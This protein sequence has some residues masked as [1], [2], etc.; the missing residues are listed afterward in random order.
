MKRLLPL[1]L[2]VTSLALPAAAFATLQVTKTHIGA[3]YAANVG[4]GRLFGEQAEAAGDGHAELH[5]RQRQRR[6]QVR[7]RDAEQ[8]RAELQ[9]VRERQWRSLGDGVALGKDGARV[10]VHSSGRGLVVVSL[11]SIYYY[12]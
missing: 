1:I 6:G 9:V 2:V 8:L 10:I 4:V 3:K 11:V 12:C 7:L 5:Q